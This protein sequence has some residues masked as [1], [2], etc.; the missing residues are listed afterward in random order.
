MPAT[1]EKQ[2][3]LFRAAL[4]TPA[5]GTGAY[6]IKH[7]L[8][9]E[10]IKHF[11]HSPTSG[12][13]LNEL[14]IVDEARLN[15][16]QFAKATQVNWPSR[17]ANAT[18]VTPSQPEIML[19]N[20]GDTSVTFTAKSA[21]STEGKAHK[22]SITFFSNREKRAELRDWWK[23]MRGRFSKLQLR[24]VPKSI[25][26]AEDLRK[27]TCKANCDCNDFKYSFEVAN[28]RKGMSDIKSSN[29][30]TP[31]IKNPTN[32]VGMCK[33]LLSLIKYLV[34]DTRAQAKL[35]ESS[36]Y[37]IK[38]S[39]D[40]PTNKGYTD[41][42]S[43]YRARRQSKDD[44]ET[45][46]NQLEKMPIRGKILPSGDFKTDVL[47]SLESYTKRISYARSN[48]VRIDSGSA[49]VAYKLGDK[50][51]IKI[52]KNKRGVAQNKVEVELFDKLI[53]EG[54]GI[55]QFFANV[56]DYDTNYYWVAYE[57]AHPLNNQS[58]KSTFGV[59]FSEFAGDV[60]KLLAVSNNY[61]SF[62]IK[63]KDSKLKTLVDALGGESANDAGYIGDI[64]Y[65]A[66]WGTVI[67]DTKLVPVLVDYGMTEEIWKNLYE[68][69]MP[70]PQRRF[71]LTSDEIRD[72]NG[73][74]YDRSDESYGT[75]PTKEKFESF[76]TK[77]LDDLKDYVSRMKHAAGHT[78]KIDSGSSR[79]VYKLNDTV[80][81]IA[82]NRVGVIQ[83]ENEIKFFNRH[84]NDEFQF[85]AKI[86]ETSKHGY[87]VEMER[88]TEFNPDS[89][90]FKDSYGVSF[91]EY[92]KFVMDLRSKKFDLIA[93]MAKENKFFQYLLTLFK[94]LMIEGGNTKFL[95]DY[96][97]LR[98]LGAVNRNGKQVPVV[99]DYGMDEQTFTTNYIK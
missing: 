83:N 24:Q 14:E 74:L 63:Y 9:K 27:M 33:H 18:S 58:F 6:D 42:Y 20:L 67:R 88:A 16:D 50:L 52:A 97:N 61:G 1:S 31:D 7:S 41:S 65:T 51:A 89:E 77:A 12:E 90:L 44:D 75:P 86:T 10:T 32:K 59:D 26:T 15:Y 71:P 13:L 54:S 47:S 3:N 98:N 57:Y 29:G 22:C 87:W 91:D 69:L 39:V 82:K 23:Q 60:D 28:S 11:T 19:T 99:I 72:V 53:K 45:T 34:A 55:E 5:K 78:E 96:I 84:A 49:R 68:A 94:E 92:E 38:R 80:V 4:G 25:L 8:D 79:A 48:I 30:Q 93:K 76:K 43:E 40:L 95:V 62:S 17:G 2:A 73:D 56:I 70:S 36:K 66:Q 81:K 46:A 35:R 85:L 21:P 64:G 37:K